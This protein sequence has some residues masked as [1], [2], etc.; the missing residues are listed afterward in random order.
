MDGGQSGGTSPYRP[1]SKQNGPKPVHPLALGLPEGVPD[2]TAGGH[3]DARHL[4]PALNFQHAPQDSWAVIQL[5]R[6][7]PA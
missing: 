3:A 4:G 2:H 5:A 7:R 1:R 6:H